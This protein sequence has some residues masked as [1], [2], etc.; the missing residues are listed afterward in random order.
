MALVLLALYATIVLGDAIP[1]R[2]ADPA[3]Q[4]RLYSAVVNASG[5]PLVALA[6]LQLAADL[7]PDNERLALRA[8][9][10]ARLAV[11]VAIGFL[12]LI[13]LKGYLLWQQVSTV[14]AARIAQLDR[15]DRMIT[16][17]RLAVQQARSVPDLQHRI[18][19]LRGPTLSPAE[20]ALPLPQLRAQLSGSLDQV[21]QTLQRQRADLPS[22]DPFG[23]LIL[24][25]R[26][27]AACLALAIGF[28]ALAQRRK[29]PVALLMEC[30][31]RLELLRSWRP[32]RGSRQ[33]RASR[34]QLATFVEELSRG[35]DAPP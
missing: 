12:L 8:G 24:A 23:L 20:L 6:L 22:A 27:L 29:A 35:V 3:W 5:F 11:P 14:D 9:F 7:A 4:Q 33:P 10:F 13:P 2:L 17:L 31:L 15:Q 34:E 18:K 16:S 1:V 32:W 26:N 25:L 21:V 30:Q 19:L 28:A